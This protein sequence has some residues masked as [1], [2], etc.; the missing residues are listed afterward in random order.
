MSPSLAEHPFGPAH[1]ALL[2]AYASALG[3]RSARA[4]SYLDEVDRE[5]DLRGLEHFVGRS[6]NYR[7][8]LLRNL[9]A[10]EE[11]DELNV[12]AA[13]MASARGLREPQAQSALDQ[14][15]AQLRRNELGGA[16]AAL[17]HAASL[18]SGFAFGW[19]SRLR[20]QLL[21]ARLALADNRPEEAE[22]TATA[23]VA[24]ASRMGA[25]R[26][27]AL[28]RV[29]GARA[30]C[31]TG[32]RDPGSVEHLLDD[33]A[34]VAAPEAWWVTAELARDFGVDRWWSVAEDRV[35]LIAA[36]AGTRAEQFGRQ[37]GKWLDRTRTSRR[38]G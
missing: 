18:G 12:A 36:G 27:V 28:A 38:R 11:A 20:H 37:A 25:P 34:R 31:A 4:F 29:E 8:W 19:K 2:A 14:A 26:Y 23:V 13:E 5:V 21:S 24:D 16:A 32:Y 22:I 7:A 33:L 1:R 15:D 35:G 9:L 10:C 6:A 3:A 17:G 30:R